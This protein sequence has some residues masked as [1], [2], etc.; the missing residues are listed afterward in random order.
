MNAVL[1]LIGLALALCFIYLFFIY[2]PLTMAESRGR[3]GC[4][5]VALCFVISPL[6]VYIILAILGKSE[7]KIREEERLRIK[8][9][10]RLSEELEDECPEPDEL[11]LEPESE[12]DNSHDDE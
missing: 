11:E 12:E 9:E 5:W 7:E 1:E 2:I 10:I 3:T 8:H 4:I 6:W